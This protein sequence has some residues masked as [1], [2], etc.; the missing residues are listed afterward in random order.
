M[1]DGEKD[2]LTIVFSEGN[3]SEEEIK[4]IS[5]AFSDVSPIQQRYYVRMSAEVLPAVL[6]FSLG[7]VLGNIAKGFFEAIGSDMYQKA[8]KKSGRFAEREGKT[9]TQVR[10]GLQRRENFDKCHD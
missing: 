8:K 9:Y 7:F 6:I 2:T 4:E 1:S 5:D 3:F 10:N